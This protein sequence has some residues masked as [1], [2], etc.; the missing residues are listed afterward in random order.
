MFG[1]TIE[2]IKVFVGNN[3]MKGNQWQK[4]RS[5]CKTLT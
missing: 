2:K 1:T 4:K 5:Y 3:K